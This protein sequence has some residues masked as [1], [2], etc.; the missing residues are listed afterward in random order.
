MLSKELCIQLPHQPPLPLPLPPPPPSPSPPP[1]PPPS[2][3]P[4]PSSSSPPPPLPPPPP[5]SASPLPPLLPP[6]PPP[7]LLPLPPPPLLPPPL[8]PLLLPP[9]SSFSPLSSASSSLLLHF[10]IFHFSRW[11]R[12][13]KLTQSPG[14]ATGFNLDSGQL[15]FGA[16]GVPLRDRG[17]PSEISSVKT[18]WL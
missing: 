16:L 14:V 7:P 2:P 9:L 1:P 15:R 12:E 11:E 10:I 4:S 3:S 8:P 5:P 13:P 6:S 18:A 17:M